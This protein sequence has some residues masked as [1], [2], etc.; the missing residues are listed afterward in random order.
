MVPWVFYYVK[1]I[2]SLVP[3]SFNRQAI[4]TLTVERPG[5]EANKYLIRGIIPALPSP[6]MVIRPSLGLYEFCNEID[7]LYLDIN[8]N[9]PKRR[10]PAN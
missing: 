5:N 8:Y 6:V 1:Q 2:S 7:K 4:K 3:R 10:T 9:Y